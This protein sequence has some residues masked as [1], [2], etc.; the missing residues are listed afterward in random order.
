MMSTWGTDRLDALSLLTK[1]LNQT[2]TMVSDS[3]GNGGRVF[4]PEATL[5]ARERQRALSDRLATWSGRTARSAFPCGITNNSV[6]LPVWDEATSPSR[7]YRRPSY[8]T[9]TSSTPPGARCKNQRCRSATPS[10]RARRQP[11]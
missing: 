8:R 3:D 10:V 7:A 2:S 11:W 6:V 5:L 4:N 1:S 9:P